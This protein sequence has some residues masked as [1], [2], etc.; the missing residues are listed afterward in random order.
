M[1]CAI[2][3]EFGITTA[4]AVGNAMTFTASGKGTV[5]TLTAVWNPEFKRISNLLYCL[6]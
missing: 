1:T 2:D 6:L 4:K 5:A 3:F